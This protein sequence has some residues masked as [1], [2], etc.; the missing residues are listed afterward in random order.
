MSVTASLSR[1]RYLSLVPESLQRIASRGLLGQTICELLLFDSDCGT[2]KR[3]EEE[4]EKEKELNTEEQ[5][6]MQTKESL[7]GDSFTSV[8]SR[9]LLAAMAG[10]HCQH[11]SDN[12]SYLPRGWRGR[13]RRRGTR[14]SDNSVDDESNKM[15]LRD[16]DNAANDF[17]EA[18]KAFTARCAYANAEN[19]F[20]VPYES[21]HPGGPLRRVMYVTKPAESG[22]VLRRTTS[23]KDV[24]STLAAESATQGINDGIWPSEEL[25]HKKRRALMDEMSRSLTAIGWEEVT[26]VFPGALPLAH[27]KICALERD[28]LS[29]W[30]NSEGRPVV[31]DQAKWLVPHAKLQAKR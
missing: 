1:K 17:T 5:I 26:V 29:S 11:C 6:L 9:P 24:Y 23:S 19:D 25:S 20:L 8:N 16:K 13:I 3:Q 14:R 27:N 30:L 18:L 31:E 12:Y 2:Y 28:M 22:V 4:K 7:K 10:V 15:R 21:A